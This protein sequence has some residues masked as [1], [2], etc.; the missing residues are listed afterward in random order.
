VIGFGH[1]RGHAVNNVTTF[2]GKRA[3]KVA[4]TSRS[5][6]RIYLMGMMRAVGPAGENLLPRAKKTQAVLA[7]LCLA[8]GER[9]L[10]GRLAGMIWDRSGEAQAKDSLRH[11][12]N[13][14]V[15][16]G[17]WLIEKDNST[18]RLD[19]SGWWVDAFDSPDRSDLLLESLYGI[20]PS[21]DQWLV[22]ERSLFENRWQATLETELNN[23]IAKKAAPEL[24]AAVS[25]RLLNFVPTH[26][27]AVRSLMIAFVEMEDRAQAI[28]EYERFRQV[29]GSSLGMAP[30]EKTVALY[31]AIRLESRVRAARP[32]NSAPQRVREAGEPLARPAEIGGA[33]TVDDHQPS[34]AVLPFRNLSGDP[35]RDHVCEGLT[36]DLVETLSRVS[37]LFVVSRLSAAAFKS[38]DRPPVEIGGA[39]GVRYLLSGSVRIAG[40]R[41]RLIGELTDAVTGAALWISRLDEKCADLLEIQNLLART[42]VQHVAP[43]VRSAELKRARIKRPEQQDAYDLLLRAQENMHNPAKA[44]FESSEQL[45]ERALAREP[46]CA[47]ALAWRAHWHVMRVGQGWSPNPTH[48]TMQADCFA[49]RAIECDATEPL[50]Y[51][52]QGH[53]A[54]YLRKEFDQAFTCFDIAL[55]INPN[56]PRAWLWSAAVHAWLGEGALAVEKVNRAMALAPYDPLI[57][58]YSGIASMSYLADRQYVR[59]IE[60]AL[61]CM[62]ENPSYTTAHKALIF[63]LVLSGREGE[64]RTPAHHLLRLEPSFTVARFRL[65]SPVSAGPLGETYCDALARAGV[66]VSD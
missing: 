46:H 38:P 23:L 48:D 40:D 51:A 8:R 28:R 22:G 52:V 57:C 49:K 11:A 5:P 62:R 63:A 64:A 34:I 58:A 55:R 26:E 25:R 35:G 36:E 42:V 54:A 61:R 2:S 47:A 56:G 27:P 31:E 37:G 32:F 65:Q 50:A 39:L 13:E 43:H 30:S 59:A 1:E 44:V 19:I 4:A 53:V 6:I 15:R 60:F 45:F 9:L 17:K 66:P 18:V 29:I 41:L 14:L 12:L 3:G 24:R 21:F 10:R 16:T 7:C 33:A 20:S